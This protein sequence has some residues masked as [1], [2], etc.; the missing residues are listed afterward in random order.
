MDSAEA[1]I[2]KAERQKVK[3]KKPKNQHKKCKTVKV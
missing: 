3:V 1:R 2:K